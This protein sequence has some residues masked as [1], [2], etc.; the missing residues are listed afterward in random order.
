MKLRGVGSEV[1][2]TQL[3]GYKIPKELMKEVFFNEEQSLQRV[4]ISSVKHKSKENVA[5]LKGEPMPPA[6]CV[7]CLLDLTPQGGELSSSFI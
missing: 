4:F 5:R 7:Y 3:Y 6:G 1:N 2:M